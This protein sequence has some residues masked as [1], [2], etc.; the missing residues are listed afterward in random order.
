M[1]RSANHGAA[2]RCPRWRVLIIVLAICG[3]T[4]SL[5]T[6]TVHLRVVQGNT[7]TSDS[8]RPMRQHLNRD[9][10][11]WMAPIPVFT[12][13]QVPTF[14]LPVSPNIPPLPTVHYDESLSNRPPPSC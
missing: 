2:N 8:T 13:L 7:V 11:Q 1:G 14:F 12:I 10:M 3:L 5:A 6:R 4:V 9:A